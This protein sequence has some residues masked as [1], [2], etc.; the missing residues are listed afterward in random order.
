MTTGHIGSALVTST[1]LEV[2]E[3]LP[4]DP[5]DRP[6][7]LFV[8]GLGHAA[9]A[10]EHWLDAAAA[11]GFPAYAVSLRG[12]GG[13]AGGVRTARLGQYVDDVVAT[14]HELPG[15]AVLIGHSLGGLVVQKALARYAAHAGVLV[16]PI[17]AHPAAGSLLALA[18]Q[19]P[20]DALR[21]M[22]GLTL[23]LRPEY[24][25]E[26]LDDGEARRLAG[27]C[28]AESAVAQFQLL[29]HRPAAPPL[30]GAPVLVLASPQDRLVPISDVRRT[31][32]R[33]GAELR[34]FPGMGHDLMLD[35]RWRE[36]L[37]ELLDWLPV[38]AR[39]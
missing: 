1:R 13:S 9:W 10:F 25:F 35:R 22:V 6:P 31:A 5:T 32:R 11:A 17:P 37:G 24:L 23:P 3:R 28:G 12:H 16:A 30:G 34:E 8:H 4:A 20:S 39:R 15:K 36:P 33:Y 26:E 38:G 19:H 29:L 27:R 7:L 21:M 14:A 18:R 2:L